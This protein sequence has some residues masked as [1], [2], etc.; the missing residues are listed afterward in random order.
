MGATGSHCGCIEHWWVISESTSLQERICVLERKHS[1]ME[2]NDNTL[3]TKYS[4]LE[5][6]YDQL[7]KKLIV[8]LQRSKHYTLNY[9]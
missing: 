4:T 7:Q 5:A 6:K 9:H 1:A 3:H 2:T 8:A